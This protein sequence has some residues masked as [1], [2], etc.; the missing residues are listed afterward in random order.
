MKSGTNTSPRAGSAR[1]R[2]ASLPCSACFAATTETP[3]AESSRGPR[4]S[5]RTIETTLDGVPALLRVPKTITQPPIVLWHG[6]GPP[7][8]EQALDMTLLLDDVPAYRHL[9]GT[10]AVRARYKWRGR[11]A[12]A[13]AGV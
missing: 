8:S 10:A 2:D 11:G 5:G 9:S 3:R 6:F 4:R 13:P 12:E 7:A 1:L